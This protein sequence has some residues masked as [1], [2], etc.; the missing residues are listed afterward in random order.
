VNLHHEADAG[1]LLLAA[2]AHL[3]GSELR[4]LAALVALESPGRP[5]RATDR[6]IARRV[7]CD[8]GHLRKMLLRLKATPF[9]PIGAPLIAV[10][11][12]THSRTIVVARIPRADAGPAPAGAAPPRPAEA[13]GISPHAVLPG[14]LPLPFAAKE[15]GGS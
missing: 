7:P 6:E 12:G 1:R 3:P 13:L 14:Q 9:A 2:A 10:A 5:I 15:G 4:V 8:P 11:G